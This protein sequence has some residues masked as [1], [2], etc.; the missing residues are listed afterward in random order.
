M[1]RQYQEQAITSQEMTILVV[2]DDPEILELI[3][4]VLQPEGYRVITAVNAVQ[5]LSLIASRRISLVLLD[6][7]LP[8]LDG[9]SACRIIRGQT[10]IP[11]IMVSARTGEEEKIAC[12]R[13]GADDYITKPFSPGEL[14]AR[15]AAVLRRGPY[16]RVLNLR[17]FHF[18]DLTVNFERRLVTLRG[19]EINLTATEFA[20][21]ETLAASAGKLVTNEILLKDV[22]GKYMPDLHLLQVNISRLR[23]KLQSGDD[24]DK[25][26]QT[27]QGL[28]YILRKR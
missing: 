14:A 19:E 17:E 26:I 12:L 15:V 2:D 25:Y 18:L 10:Q 23:Q 11:V 20:I 21:L 1:S 5:A 3:S 7:M 16:Q 24:T 9:L 4:E 8:D 27:K 22:W 6:I 13:A 28:G